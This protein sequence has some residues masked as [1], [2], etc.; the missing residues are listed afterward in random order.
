MITNNIG[1]KIAIVSGNFRL[2]KKRYTGSSIILMK[3]DMRR[4]IMIIFP[5][6]I[7][8]PIRKSPRSSIESFRVT[9]I[10][11]I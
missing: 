5:I 6:T 11:F 10:S 9:G 7:I 1:K 4:G 2:L 3:N 8:Q